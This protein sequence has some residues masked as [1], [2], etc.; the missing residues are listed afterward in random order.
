MIALLKKYYI[1][2]L[3]LLPS[4]AW[5]QGAV[6]AYPAPWSQVGNTV[7]LSASGTSSNAQLG[8]VGV[9]SP[10]P[11]VANV[12]NTGSN[13]AYVLLGNS[14]VSVTTSTGTIVPAGLCSLIAVNGNQYIAGITASSTTTLS[15][16]VGVGG[17]FSNAGS[18]GSGGGAV[19]SVTGAG[20]V[21]CSPTTGAVTCTGSA[22]PPG[23]S[24]GAIQYN[25]SG[26]FGGASIAGLVKGNGSSAPTAAVSGTDYAPPTSGSSI[27]YGN[28]SGGFSNATIGAGLSFSGG[29]LATSGGGSVPAYITTTAA[30]TAQSVF[31]VAY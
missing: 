3:L 30:L 2:S 7:S 14:S 16:G 17:P 28:G 23:G 18:S 25:N 9:A 24:S 27:L 11:P 13:A 29:T 21:S 22:T 20:T 12:C 31:G 5:A 26:S 8:W 15:I 1:L 4:L 19:S 6:T 10:A